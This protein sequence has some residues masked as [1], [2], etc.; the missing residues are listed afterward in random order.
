M[1]KLDLSKFK[2]I[3]SDKKSTTLQHKDGH[4]LTLTHSALAPESQAQ[5]SALSKVS[6][7]YQTK[8]QADEAQNNKMA[9]GGDVQPKQAPA[10]HPDPDKAKA[11]SDYEKGTSQPAQNREAPARSM[12]DAFDK[13]THPMAS[14]GTVKSGSPD[15]NMAEGGQPRQ[16]M[17]EGDPNVRPT[18]EQLM[19]QS[20]SDPARL[21]ELLGTAVG[22]A[23]NAIKG[24]VKAI[25]E[26]ASKAG[27]GFSNNV[28]KTSG[29]DLSGA[30][31]QEPQQ[32]PN[33][34]GAPPP[35]LPPG[36]QQ[37]S[38]LPP[39]QAPDQPP[40]QQPPAAQPQPDLMDTQTAKGL[41]SS[42]ALASKGYNAGLE[43]ANQTGKAIALKGKEEAQQR[44]WQLSKQVDAQTAYQG[45][46]DNV[47]REL[48]HT[49][50]DIRNGYID[51]NK[52]WTGYTA[53]NGDKI[54]GH[55]KINAAIGLILGSINPKGAPGQ[56]AD[57][58]QGQIEQSIK[59]Q[60]DNLQS[61]QNLYKANLERFKNERDAADMTRLQ[62]AD[63]L[64]N[65]IGMAS[66]RAAEPA[67]KA[68]AAKIR[69]QIA[70]KYYP[71]A[72]NLSM[73]QAFSKV[74]GGTANSADPSDTTVAENLANQ[75]A[76]NNPEMSKELRGHI[77]SGI[78]VSPN[79]VP[80]DARNKILAHKNFDTMIRRYADFAQQ[81]RDNW[82][83][84]NL[85]DRT[86]VLNEGRSLGA[87]VSTILNNTLEGGVSEGQRAAINRILPENAAKNF[88]DITVMPQVK[89]LMESNESRAN[90]LRQFY[91]LPLTHGAPAQAP[92]QSQGPQI[93]TVNGVKYMRGPNGEA[94]PVK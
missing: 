87:E 72:F 42:N 35:A 79:L 41:P 66:A 48:D 59:A 16:M 40:Q 4:L 44:D 61:N 51:P 6:K 83:N 1:I 27:Q 25:G 30:D 49:Q 15:M 73:R 17:A 3:K 28:Q 77:V 75:A 47:R 45:E 64:Q 58:L 10:F 54:A 88:P 84:M 69:Q 2:H 36:A 7:Q 86:K 71:I 52:Y 5:L 12:S 23:V 33:P 38:N 37:V 62:M 43:E 94:I 65:R 55:S 11:M 68:E 46:L 56:G 81:H 57:F 14:G 91:K 82:K 26:G 21:P 13:L 53:A 22:H 76:V 60:Q 63:E 9:E 74:V 50:N 85:V 67:A 8:T 92:A 80:D 89:A 93:K 31:E 34:Q 78:G 39:Q 24:G 18:A 32:P 70:E 29:V 20:W 19:S 90:T